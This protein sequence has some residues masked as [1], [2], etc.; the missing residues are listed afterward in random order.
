MKRKK[1]K[2]KRKKKNLRKRVK[3]TTTMYQKRS[4]RKTHHN[5]FTSRNVRESGG[6]GDQ[7]V[8]IN[9]F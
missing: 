3:V 6:V 1:K 7:G 2:R 4:K 9:P 8:I 5:R